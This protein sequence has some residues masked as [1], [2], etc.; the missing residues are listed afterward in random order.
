LTQT[1]GGVERA[2]PSIGIS[3]CG[4]VLGLMMVVMVSA[5]VAM[6]STMLAMIRM[7]TIY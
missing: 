5:V 2:Q 3:A 7:F 6:V 4:L 1:A